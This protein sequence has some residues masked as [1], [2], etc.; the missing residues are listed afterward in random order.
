MGSWVYM[1]AKVFGLFV[2][3]DWGLLDKAPHGSE[4]LVY[5]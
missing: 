4:A 1:Y 2:D 3:Y 5:K